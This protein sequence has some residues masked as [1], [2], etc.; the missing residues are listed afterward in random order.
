MQATH[1]ALSGP[2]TSYPTAEGPASEAKDLPATE[3]REPPCEG[4]AAPYVGPGAAPKNSRVRC[5]VSAY[6]QDLRRRAAPWVPLD[7]SMHPRDYP[8]ELERL[9]R[10]GV[11]EVCTANTH[12]VDLFEPSEIW[13]IDHEQPMTAAPGAEAALEEMSPGEYWESKRDIWKADAR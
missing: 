4:E 1:C 7:P 11:T 8:A 12:I 3:V 5:W 13:S 2:P 6:S 9:R 10:K